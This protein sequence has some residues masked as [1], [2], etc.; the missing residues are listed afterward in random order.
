MIEEIQ[1]ANIEVFVTMT[2]RF[3]NPDGSIGKRVVRKQEVDVE[4]I[5]YPVDVFVNKK[6]VFSN[7]DSQ[8]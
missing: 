1:S 6:L 3:V 2:K 4:Y 5:G 8:K 7:K